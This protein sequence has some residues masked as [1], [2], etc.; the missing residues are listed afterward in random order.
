ML[1]LLNRI[2][3][4]EKKG[5]EKI[6]RHGKT[7]M[8]KRIVAGRGGTSKQM[9]LVTQKSNESLLQL[10]KQPTFSSFREDETIK[11]DILWALKC[12]QSNYAFASKHDSSELHRSMFPDSN[13]A[14]NYS[15]AETKI[16]YIVDFGIATY[17]REQLISDLKGAPFTFLFDDTTAQ[18]KSSKKT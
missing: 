5:L 14:L 8:H 9:T 7:S 1:T 11:A 2:S 12:I 3:Y 4:L 6:R 15:M 13:I 18:A 16:R 10:S 17:V